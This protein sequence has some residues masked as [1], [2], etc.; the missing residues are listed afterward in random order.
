MAS[1]DSSFTLR[2]PSVSAHKRMRTRARA[3]ASTDSDPDE[4]DDVAL[5]RRRVARRPRAKAA[6][7]KSAPKQPAEAARAGRKRRHKPG[8]VHD[9]PNSILDPHGSLQTSSDSK[10]HR[11]QAS[12]A[13]NETSDLTSMEDIASSMLSDNEGKRLTAQSP[14]AAV[15]RDVPASTPGTP[16]VSNSQPVPEKN[17]RADIGIP[18]Q[19]G[20][21][22]QRG[23]DA[24]SSFQADGASVVRDQ[25]I[26]NEESEGHRTLSFETKKTTDTADQR[27]IVSP[28]TPNSCRKQLDIDTAKND[29][30]RSKR[31]PMIEVTWS[32]KANN[33]DPDSSA[34]SQRVVEHAV[35]TENPLT[36]DFHQEESPKIPTRDRADASDFSH[37]DDPVYM[38]RRARDEHSGSS[39]NEGRRD[40]QTQTMPAPAR[41]PAQQQQQQQQQPRA[42]TSFAAAIAPNKVCTFRPYATA[43]SSARGACFLCG[44]AH[45]GGILGR[46]EVES[47]PAD[48]RIVRQMYTS[49]LYC[50]LGHPF[51]TDVPTE[52]SAYCECTAPAEE[53]QGR[54]IRL[55]FLDAVLTRVEEQM[56]GEGICVEDRVKFS[57]FAS[58]SGRL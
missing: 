31:Y 25:K 18:P 51:G 46:C 53:K 9:P 44:G 41:A 56:R 57:V 32:P 14:G 20:F 23:T 48:V 35:G 43:A 54:R 21:E 3:P 4:H 7:G 40:R 15:N 47:T 12:L 49:L 10:K 50:S 28:A 2:T 39:R 22:C 42:R 5:P 52:G 27:A 33:Y 17:E 36:D 55:K 8:D 6:S 38:T 45:V 13:E 19:Q 37:D 1:S 26:S 11:R 34:N 29:D 16:H 30:E 58:K 24:V